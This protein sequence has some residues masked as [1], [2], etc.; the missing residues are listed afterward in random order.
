MTEQSHAM[1]PPAPPPMGTSPAGATSRRR[2]R[3]WLVGLVVTLVLVALVAGGEFFARRQLRSTVS[4]AMANG[5]HTSSVDV[6][7]GTSPALLDLSRGR[8]DQVS[9][10]AQ[11]ATVCQVRD[12]SLDAKVQ[13]VS[14]ARSGGR[15]GESTLTLTLSERALNDLLATS[16]SAKDVTATV[17]PSSGSVRLVGLGGLAQVQA[18]PSLTGGKLGFTVVSAQFA[19]HDV[20]PARAQK[21]L[22][23]GSGTALQQMPLGLRATSVHVTDAGLETSFHGQPTTLPRGEQPLNCAGR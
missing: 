13:D 16:K 19:G 6:G 23:G 21:L 3:P 15:I 1:A 14:T 12:V 2:R 11:Q 9:L 7:I 8:I 18:R 10:K 5:L 20:Q 4:D 22:G 17:E